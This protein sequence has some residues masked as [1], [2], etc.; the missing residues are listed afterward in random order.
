VQVVVRQYTSTNLTDRDA[1]TLSDVHNLN[2]LSWA[3]KNRVN[4]KVA[5]KA[6][7][8][9]IVYIDRGGHDRSTACTILYTEYNFTLYEPVP[10]STLDQVFLNLRSGFENNFLTAYF[11]MGSES[12]DVV[13]SEQSSLES[14]VNASYI[15]VIHNA[16]DPRIVACQSRNDFIADPIGYGLL[17]ANW[18]P[19]FQLRIL[20]EMYP[21]SIDCPFVTLSNTVTKDILYMEQNCSSITGHETNCSFLLENETL[22]C[23]S[24]LQSATWRT[25]QSQTGTDHIEGLLTYTCMGVLFVCCCL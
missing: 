23:V 2:E 13:V 15:T 21:D 17:D 1:L 9:D 12:G 25:L 6:N 24:A 11:D 22:I 4:I 3:T 7:G 19:H 18:V 20:S 16:S 5:H 14:N 8:D 10:I